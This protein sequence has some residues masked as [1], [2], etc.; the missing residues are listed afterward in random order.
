MPV[1]MK[2]MPMTVDGARKWLGTMIDEL[3][4][5]F[6][7]DILIKDYCWGESEKRYFTSSQCKLLESQRDE[8]FTAFEKAGLDIYG[9]GLAIL[10]QKRNGGNAMNRPNRDELEA[11]VQGLLC[12]RKGTPEDMEEAAERA[13][14]LVAPV[15]G[16][17]CPKCV[18]A[19]CSDF[20]KFGK[21]G[22][23]WTSERGPQVGGSPEHW[24]VFVKSEPTKMCGVN[25]W[26]YEAACGKKFEAQ[27]DSGD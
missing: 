21:P 2:K 14:K 25:I 27:V 16:R 15:L 8:A 9:E 6:H 17:D 24:A 26:K 12:A 13:E 11:R 20:P 10:H 3:G 22:W 7:P 4:L 1:P 18:D 5:S 23:G 19:F